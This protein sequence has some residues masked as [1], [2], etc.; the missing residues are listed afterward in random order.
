MDDETLWQPFGDYSL[1]SAQ[2][3]HEAHGVLVLASTPAE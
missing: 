2:W 3:M 1:T